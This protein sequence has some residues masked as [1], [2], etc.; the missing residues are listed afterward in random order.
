M[1]DELRSDGEV[2]PD[3][4]RRL[5]AV[6]LR[7]RPPPTTPRS[8]PGSASGRAVPDV[9]VAAFDKRLD[10]AYGENP[11]QRAAYYAERGA[12]THLL[13]R[14][15]QLHGRELSFN[16]LNDLERGAAARARVR[17]ARLR[18]RQ[19][20]EPVR[21]RGRR[22]DRGGVRRARSPAIPVSAYGG[23]V[24]LNRPVSAA[25]GERAR[26]AVR[27]GAVRARLRRGGARG[28]RRASRRRGSSTTSSAAR[29]DPA[30]A[31][32][33]ACSAACSCR[34]ATRSR[35][36]RARWRSSAASRPRQQWGDLLFA[37]RVCKHV[38]SNAIVLAKGL[39]T[40][41]IGAGQMSRVDAVRIAVEKAREHGH[42]S[43][44]AALAS[45]AFFPF[46]GRPAAR[47]RRGRDGAH[48]AG[49]LEARRRGRRRG[50]SGRRRDGLHRP[51]AATSGTLSRQGV[52]FRRRCPASTRRCSTSSAPRRSSGSTGS[53]ARSAPTLLAKLEY[54]NPGG[55]NK[56]RIGMA[57]IEAAERDG[58]LKPGGTIVEP[59]SGNTGVGPRDRG[60]RARL[61][62]HLRDARQD[63]PG[64]DL[65]A[66]RL[67]RR[68]RDHADRGR[69]RLAGELLLGLRP[70]RRGDPGR[71][72]ARPVLE[73]GQPG[74][75][76]RDDRAGD[77]GADGRRDRRA[78]DLGRHRRHDLG[79]RPLPE[80]AQ[81]RTS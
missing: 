20:R 17:A 10:L 22:D 2:S 58:K 7:A 65:D 71:L 4:R 70:A 45:D 9:L 36:P 13:S 81:A 61:P 21:R 59:T 60:G 80:G 53:A 3:T 72:Q 78:R 8:R 62:L 67:R 51:T 64:E 15:E 46:A 29:V 39:Q 35:R 33:S 11:H 49:R 38:T 41:G 23:V 16:N 76:L 14:V 68:G 1:L 54:L 25:L 27:R 63:E 37:W 56:D 79:R 77:L 48:P 55:S 73:H 34:T 66:A 24:V 30:S 69:A 32:S 57:M 50:R 28:A 52:G 43:T 19:A 74:G 26:R 12:R 44:G 5:A 42:D 6:G 18:D 75:A 47:A 40:I 31:T